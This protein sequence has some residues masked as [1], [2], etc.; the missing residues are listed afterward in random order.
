MAAFA[1][2]LT[3]PAATTA[4]SV[5]TITRAASVS[6]TTAGSPSMDHCLTRFLLSE[7]F[8]GSFDIQVPETF[9]IN[10][11]AFVDSPF[12]NTHLLR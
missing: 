3:P 4:S 9:K 6:P 2:P 7:F 10:N 8:S 5:Y 11:C 1:P 12:P